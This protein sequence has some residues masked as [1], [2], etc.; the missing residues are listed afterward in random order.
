ML[1]TLLTI[2]TVKDQ[3][4]VSFPVFAWWRFFWLIL[5]C[6]WL[7]DVIL[8]RRFINWIFCFPMKNFLVADSHLMMKIQLNLNRRFENSS[9][10]WHSAG[11]L[12]AFCVL[13]AESS[14][15]SMTLLLNV[16]QSS[17]LISISFLQSKRCN[18]P[19]E[20]KQWRKLCFEVNQWINSWTLC[21]VAVC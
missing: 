4:V 17:L 10:F 13:I 3:R 14:G 8:R 6:W 9:H 16:H 12:T 11:I 7:L 20:R 19:F 1:N 15:R 18:S 2:F 21:K 5:N